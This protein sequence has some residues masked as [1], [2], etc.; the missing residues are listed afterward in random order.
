MATIPAVCEACQSETAVIY[1]RGA[2]FAHVVG[3][4][5]TGA[6]VDVVS[7]RMLCQRCRLELLL[8]TADLLQH[9]VN[10]PTYWGK[11]M[12]TVPHPTTPTPTDVPMPPPH[13]T[14]EPAPKPPS[15]PT[16]TP[17]PPRSA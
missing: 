16:P 13:P 6:A 3:L 4:G 8:I 9:F 12:P 10:R 17:R 11:D 5:H 1:P 14:P 2:L 7:D 15:T